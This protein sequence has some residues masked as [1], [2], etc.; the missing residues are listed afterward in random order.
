MGKEARFIPK[1]VRDLG[2]S[3]GTILAHTDNTA[4]IVYYS[5]RF[6]ISHIPQRLQHLMPMFTRALFSLGTSNHSEVDMAHKIGSA[7]GGVN[8]S[9]ANYTTDADRVLVRRLPFDMPPSL[10]LTLFRHDP[11]QGGGLRQSL[12]PQDAR[13]G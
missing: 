9:T 11:G 5:L 7:T 3:K 12:E 10:L 8:I 1:D 6:D 4:G 2:N 13:H